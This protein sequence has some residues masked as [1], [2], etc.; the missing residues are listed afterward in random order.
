MTY[1]PSLKPGDKCS[2][3][4]A[5]KK[6]FPKDGIKIKEAKNELMMC[7]IPHF[8]SVASNSMYGIC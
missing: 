1:F 6:E 5:N 4:K 8:I 7:S 3:E 2:G